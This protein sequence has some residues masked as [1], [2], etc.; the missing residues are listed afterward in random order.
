[1]VSAN[2]SGVELLGSTPSFLSDFCADG[3]AI[4]RAIASFNLATISGSERPCAGAVASAR[5][6]LPVD[7]IGARSGSQSPPG[8]VC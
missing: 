8:A 7:H 4:A 6:F 2:A 1:M 3:V 5:N